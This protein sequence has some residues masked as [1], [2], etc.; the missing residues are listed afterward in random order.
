VEAEVDADAED[1]EEA[2]EEVEPEVEEVIFVCTP[3]CGLLFSWSISCV[4]G[5]SFLGP[6]RDCGCLGATEGPPSCLDLLGTKEAK[7]FMMCRAS[8]AVGL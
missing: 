6:G 8:Y 2:E 3:M 1:A 5:L 7:G 4:R